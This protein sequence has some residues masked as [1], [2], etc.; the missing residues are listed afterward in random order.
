MTKNNNFMV[1]PR[2]GKNLKVRIQG[3]NSNVISQPNIPT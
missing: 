3:G 1:S 2:I